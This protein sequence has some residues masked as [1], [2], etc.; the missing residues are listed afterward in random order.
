MMDAGLVV[1]VSLVSPFRADREL[2]KERFAEGDF[3]EVFVDTPLEICMQRDPKGLYA[4]SQQDSTMQ[5]TGVGQGYEK[6]LDPT[7]TLDGTQPVEDSV[8]TL[9]NLLLSRRIQ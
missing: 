4:R 6:P 3:I 2:A 8:Q 9:L 7:V 5:M 1:I